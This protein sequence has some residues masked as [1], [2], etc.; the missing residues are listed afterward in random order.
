MPDEQ[1]L[2]CRIHPRVL[3]RL[4]DTLSARLKDFETSRRRARE[5]MAEVRDR[6]GYLERTFG[7]PLDECRVECDSVLS[8]LE[9]PG[10]PTQ[11]EVDAQ[12]QR[13]IR[14]SAMVGAID[15]AGF[16]RLQGNNVPPER[17]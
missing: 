13:V 11:G 3:H 6:I 14:L 5:L 7:L 16:S 8:W 9:K 10:A 17:L 15:S 1:T 12:I 2:P 4:T